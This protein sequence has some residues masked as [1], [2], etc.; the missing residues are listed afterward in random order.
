[1][2]GTCVASQ[3][4]SSC[5]VNWK[6]QFSFPVSGSKRQQAVA[7]EVVAGATRTAIGW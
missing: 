3:S 6:Y 5:L 7:V 2:I 4:C 1:M